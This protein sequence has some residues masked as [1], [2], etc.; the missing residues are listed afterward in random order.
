VAGVVDDVKTDLA[1]KINHD[2]SGFYVNLHTAALTGGAVRGQLFR[3]GRDAAAFDSSSFV[4]PVTKGEQIYACTKQADGSFAFTQ[5]N[6][7]A[8]LRGGIAHSFV[9]DA[10]GPPQW[11]ARDRSSVTGKVLAR[12]P[13]GA[14]NIPELDLDATQT[15]ASNG[16]LAGVVE[17]E[18]LNTVGGVAPTGPCDPKSQPTVKVP[19]EADYLFLK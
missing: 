8:R 6:V 17:I 5:H 7:S 16:L 1:K 15:G 2:P 18:R 4:A 13:N 3:S 12:T 10:A 19:Y 14:G 11:V 9:K